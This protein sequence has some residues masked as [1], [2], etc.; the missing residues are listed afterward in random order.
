MRILPA[1]SLR[2][3]GEGSSAQGKPGPKPRPKGVGDGQS[4]E[5]PMPPNFRLEDGVTQQGRPSARMEKRAQARRAWCRK[6]RTTLSLRGNGEGTKYRSGRHLHCQE[7]PL[8]RKPVPVPQT[9]T[10][11]RGENPKARERTLVKELGKITP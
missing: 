6:N 9:D 3:P 8:T 10:G 5:N 1:E 4:V 11:R 2:I 7:K